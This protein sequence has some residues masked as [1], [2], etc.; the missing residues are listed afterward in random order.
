VV[1]EEA[2]TYVDQESVDLACIFLQPAVWVETVAIF[3]E[4]FGIA[5]DDPRV[6]AKNGLEF[7]VNDYHT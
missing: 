1:L 6:H 7:V 2:Y 4:Y 5:V 3:A